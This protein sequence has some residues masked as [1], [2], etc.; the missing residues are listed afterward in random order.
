[1][2]K[3]SF[4]K[5]P[6]SSFADYILD[7]LTPY[8]RP[9]FPDHL[10]QVPPDPEQTFFLGNRYADYGLAILFAFAFPLLRAVL[11]KFIYTVSDAPS[12][13]QSCVT[14]SPIPSPKHTFADKCMLL[15]IMNGMGNPQ[16]VYNLILS[17]CDS[18]WARP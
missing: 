13:M 17:P 15:N 7:L 6:S 4:I 16:H 11:G 9:D 18:P 10:R 12:F 2:Q 3:F 14:R 8:A 1:M 5:M